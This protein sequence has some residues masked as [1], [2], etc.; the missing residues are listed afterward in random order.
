MAHDTDWSLGRYFNAGPLKALYDIKPRNQQDMK[1]RGMAGLQPMPLV[2]NM[3]LYSN[4]RPDWSVKYRQAPGV[5]PPLGYSVNQYTSPFRSARDSET[6]RPRSGF[7]SPKG[8][9][10]TPTLTPSRS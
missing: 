7:P 4:G 9:S 8:D 1:T 10:R 5:G 2:G 6:V 3:D